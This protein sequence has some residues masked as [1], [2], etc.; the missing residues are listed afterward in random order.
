MTS[1]RRLATVL[2]ALLAAT[3]ATAAH[4]QQPPPFETKKIADDVYL[5]R[6][7]AHQS[8]FVV[9][10][11]GVIATD[12]IGYR[13]P[14]AVQT[15]IDEI[16]KVTPAPIKYVVYSHHH[17]DHI[18]GGRPFKDLG[19][20][21]IAHKNAKAHLETL[22]NPDVVLPDIGTGDLHVIILGGTRLELHYVG[23]NHSDNSLVMLLP[24]QK[25]LFVVD[26]IPIEAVQFRDLPDGFLPDFFESFDKVLALDW[27]R[28]I[29]GHPYAG[30]RL[31]TKDDVRAA[32]QYM[33][34]LSDAVK[35]AALA[36]KCFDDA[37]KEIKLP[38][39]EKWANYERYLPG[40]IERFCEYWGRG[41]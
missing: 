1:H 40:N 34:D 9:T 22:K 23:R 10:P 24:K 39:Y 37:M 12:P 17:Y 4:A 19:A 3:A 30:G 27:D 28:M 26:F 21:F 6:Y 18:E 2:L 13:R 15:Y 32:K 7:G 20:T 36:G 29:P 14:P 31:G 5:F 16:R 38:K 8:M 33:V 35:P 25:L 41:Y 11:D